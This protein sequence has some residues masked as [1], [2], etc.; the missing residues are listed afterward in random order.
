[1][2]A[3][4]SSTSAVVMMV[5]I[6]MC[7]CCGLSSSS[8]ERLCDSNDPSG[9]CKGSDSRG[10]CNHEY[11]DGGIKFQAAVIDRLGMDYYLKGTVSGCLKMEIAG[12]APAVYTYY[13][14]SGTVSHCEDSGAAMGL[15]GQARPHRAS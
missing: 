3:Q 12:V 1:M 9:L 11:F 14:C 5:T 7:R 10:R 15:C 8:Y 6:I 13:C 2:S 4:S